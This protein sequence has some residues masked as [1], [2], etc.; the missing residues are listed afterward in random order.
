MYTLGILENVIS[1]H[2]AAAQ[3][4]DREL[5]NPQGAIPITAVSCPS[6]HNLF[7]VGS[8]RALAKIIPNSRVIIT[9]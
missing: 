9:K 6:V 7:I 3:M 4:H 5:E 2:F 8:E 1:T